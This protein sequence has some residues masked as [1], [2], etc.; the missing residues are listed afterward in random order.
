MIVFVLAIL[1]AVFTIASVLVIRK[2]CAE[3]TGFIL[4]CIAGAFY[5]VVIVMCIIIVQEYLTIGSTVKSYEQRYEILTYQIE[6]NIYD[7]DND[8]GKLQLY[9]KIQYWNEDLAYRKQVQRDFWIGIFYPNVYD[10][11]EFID[12]RVD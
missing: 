6:N 8:V 2:T 10:Q 5:A 9:E 3:I 4:G 11:F 12:Y 7:N 1:G